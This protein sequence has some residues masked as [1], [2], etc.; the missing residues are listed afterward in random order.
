MA[1]AFS[2]RWAKIATRLRGYRVHPGGE[3][4]EREREREIDE[5]RKPTRRRWGNNVKDV[6][7]SALN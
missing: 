6:G 7:A 2:S 5:A 4:E 1:A 3:G